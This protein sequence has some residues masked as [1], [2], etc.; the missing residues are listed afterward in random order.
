MTPDQFKEIVF[1]NLGKLADIYYANPEL[2]KEFNLE[3]REYT[4][5]GADFISLSVWE[6]EE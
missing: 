2:K 4:D 1:K 3:I 5:K 6:K